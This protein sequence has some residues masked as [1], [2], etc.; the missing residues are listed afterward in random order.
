MFARMASAMVW[1]G[2][3]PYMPAVLVAST[4]VRVI[5]AA[6]SATSRTHSETRS[7]SSRSGARTRYSTLASPGTTLAAVPP[8]RTT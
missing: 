1:F 3:T 7:T 6:A 2:R 8:F 5:F 4:S